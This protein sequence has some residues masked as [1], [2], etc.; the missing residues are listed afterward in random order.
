MAVSRGDG[1]SG[2]KEL[3]EVLRGE[4]KARIE[5]LETKERECRR[6][7]ESLDILAVCIQ[8]LEGKRDAE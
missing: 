4:Y 2:A 6:E 3:L 1:L 5:A 7:R 8:G